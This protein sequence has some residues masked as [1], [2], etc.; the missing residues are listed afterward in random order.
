MIRAK[1]TSIG[2]SFWIL[3]PKEQIRH[4]NL[5]EGDVIEVNI[6]NKAIPLDELN[7]SFQCSLCKKEFEDRDDN[8]NIFCSSC[9]ASKNNIILIKKYLVNN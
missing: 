3:I 7:A 5:K 8:K 6:L 2:T 1:L 9:G 4:F